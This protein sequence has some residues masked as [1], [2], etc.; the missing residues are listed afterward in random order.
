M[1]ILAQSDKTLLKAVPDWKDS[2]NRTIVALDKKLVEQRGKWQVDIV[3]QLSNVKANCKLNKLYAMVKY[4]QLKLSLFY[5]YL[6]K[7]SHQHS[8]KTK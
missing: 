7:E 3:E 5:F 8:Q 4:L 1:G 2:N 6:G